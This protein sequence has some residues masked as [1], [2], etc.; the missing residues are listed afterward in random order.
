MSKHKAYMPKE[1]FQQLHGQGIR[2]EAVGPL[3]TKA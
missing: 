1:K 2:Q 3:I